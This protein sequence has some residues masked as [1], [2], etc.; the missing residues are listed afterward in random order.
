[1]LFVILNLQGVFS[2]TAN[3]PPALCCDGFFIIDVHKYIEKS[4]RKMLKNRREVQ[5]QALPLHTGH[6]TA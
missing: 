3:V 5:A 1:M 6:T 4:E 2:L